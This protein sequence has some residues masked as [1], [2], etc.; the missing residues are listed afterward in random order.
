MWDRTLY[1]GVPGLKPDSEDCMWRSAQLH[2]RSTL[3]SLT[4]HSIFNI[5]LYAAS[6]LKT[7]REASPTPS[8][9]MRAIELFEEEKSKIKNRREHGVGPMDLKGRQAMSGALD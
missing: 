6:A 2:A 7:L 8:L 3:P 5:T 1:L 9:H 4:L